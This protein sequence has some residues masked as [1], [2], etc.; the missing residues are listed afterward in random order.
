MKTLEKI[1]GSGSLFLFGILFPLLLN[2]QNSGV[3]GMQF[4]EI[5]PSAPAF[6]ISESYTAASLGPST[7]YGNPANMAFESRSS[8]GVDYTLWLLDTRLSHA[9]GTFVSD[10]HAFGAGIYND[11]INDIPARDGPGE[12]DGT[13]SVSYLSVAGAYAHSIGQHVAIGVTGQFL[14]EQYLVNQASGYAFNLGVSTRWL[15]D[16]IRAAATVV[17]LGAMSKLNN[18]ATQL[19]ANARFGISAD[20]VEFTTPGPN[21]LPVLVTFYTDFVHPL[22]NSSSDELTSIADETNDP[23][24]NFGTEISFGD[25]GVLRTGYKT[26]S[27][28]NFR[29]EVRKMS[30]GAGFWIDDFLFNYTHIPLSSGYQNGNSIGIQYYF[31]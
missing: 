15:N 8:L 4:L 22:N 31:D 28:S 12:P 7:L 30:I 21:D 27:A 26:T 11:K 20:L 25:V 29:Q 2:A 10:D 16:R 17:N 1:I 24:F 6:G 9:S 23:S 18:E 3:T 19:P 14:N 5:G 13:F